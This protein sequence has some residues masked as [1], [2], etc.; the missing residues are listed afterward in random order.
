VG[1]N[2]LDYQRRQAVDR[3]GPTEK[4]F[5]GIRRRQRRRENVAELRDFLLGIQALDALG[6]VEDFLRRKTRYAGLEELARDLGR[7]SALRADQGAQI[8]AE[9]VRICAKRSGSLAAPLLTYSEYV[10][11]GR[12]R[13][14][15]FMYERR[16][17]Y[18]IAEYYQRELEAGA[19]GTR[20]TCAGRPSGPHPDPADPNP[21]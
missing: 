14:P 19:C 21:V 8:L 18:D 7:P 20:S 6:S 4:A 10:R 12:K 15:I 13:A 17:I 5:A 1:G 11:L 2:P 3:A 16:D 9:I